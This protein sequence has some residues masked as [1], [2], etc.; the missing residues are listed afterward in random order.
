MLRIP[1]GPETNRFLK[2]GPIVG[3]VV[4]FSVPLI[5]VVTIVSLSSHGCFAQE[6]QLDS[7]QMKL[8][9]ER[10]AVTV[11]TR[12]Q[13]ELLKKM[14]AECPPFDSTHGEPWE[15]VI[16]QWQRKQL[17]QEGIRVRVLPEPKL[18]QGAHRTEYRLLREMDLEP[19]NAKVVIFGPK[20][21]KGSALSDI[22]IGVKDTNVCVYDSSFNLIRKMYLRDA[23]FS[24]N[25]R[26]MGGI[27][28]V[29]HPS[30]HHEDTLPS[31][32]IETVEGGRTFDKFQL[33]D[34]TGRNLWESEE[35]QLYEVN[36]TYSI[37]NKGTV[38]ELDHGN[39]MVTFFDQNG[40]ETSKIRVCNVSGTP[41]EGIAGEM[42]SDDGEYVLIIADDQCPDTLEARLRILFFTWD[43]RELWR[44]TT[45][46][47]AEG[48]ADVSEHG[49]YVIVSSLV[50]PP[51]DHDYPPHGKTTY[52]LSGKGALIRKY[53]NVLGSPVCFSSNEK[54]A[55]F[56]SYGVLF[57][58]DLPTGKVL[59]EHTRGGAFDQ[60]NSLD[61]AEDA[62]L[63]G[64]ATA[65]TV[66]LVGL[67]GRQMWS[68]DFPS[69]DGRFFA[70]LSDD[71]DQMAV[72]IGSKV[73]IYQRIR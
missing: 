73:M 25:L 26:Y 43:G 24:Q 14:V 71:G 28:Y 10:V 32:E 15:F 4:F 50:W 9:S 42:F 65:S 38:I 56:D 7:S 54:Y 18:D 36:S 72:V 62:K 23:I 6:T 47:N 35:K 70:R 5:L 22:I 41:G 63:I 66:V 2:T 34:Y 68:H 3:L 31:G 53:E 11:K 12:A 29:E 17:E 51:P 69:V 45:E 40:H 49:N 67:D 20:K 59:L 37:S 39:G 8:I 1:P 44:S 61:I 33:F 52:L 60:L 57:L 55:L 46:E 30:L 58:I 64:L 27:K 16:N 13:H 21:S 19:E 48:D